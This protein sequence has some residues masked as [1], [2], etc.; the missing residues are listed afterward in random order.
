MSKLHDAPAEDFV[1]TSEMRILVRRIPQTR[2]PD[3]VLNILQQRWVRGDGSEWRDVP[4][5]EED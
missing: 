1:R 5:V 2:H 3:K 4:R